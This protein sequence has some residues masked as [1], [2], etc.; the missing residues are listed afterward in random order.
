MQH[1]DKRRA[2]LISAL[3]V[4]FASFAAEQNEGA[5]EIGILPNISARML[6]TQYEP[7]RRYLE[8]VLGRKV[9]ISTAQNWETFHK[10]T[11]EKEYD[12]V[13]TAVH[14]G[15]VAEI[16]AGYRPLLIYKARSSSKPSCCRIRNHS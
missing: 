6:L 15:R 12:V 14:L 5:L 9:Q 11:L 2:L 4:P 10:R 3:C 1:L 16:D 7:M 8:R 13:I